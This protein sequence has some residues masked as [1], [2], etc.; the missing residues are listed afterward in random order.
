MLHVSRTA[1]SGQHLAPSELISTRTRNRT[2]TAAGA[3]GPTLSYQFPTEVESIL[4][5]P[6]NP[7]EPQALR[8][9]L[10]K[11]NFVSTYCRCRR[12]ASNAVDP[13]SGNR[14]AVA[15]TTSLLGSARDC[16][17]SSMPALPF[18]PPAVDPDNVAMQREFKSTHTLIG[19][20]NSAANPV[21]IQRS[22]LILDT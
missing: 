12:T 14:R 5:A 13:H 6:T 19:L 4:L 16:V 18:A 17:D 8:S 2:A 21:V 1:A 22:E 11:T 7:L 20:R 9:R 10:R 3:Q 15:S